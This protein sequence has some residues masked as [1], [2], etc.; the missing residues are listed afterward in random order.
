MHARVQRVQLDGGVLGLR[1]AEVGVEVQ[2]RA[3]GVVFLDHAGVHHSQ[4]SDSGRREVERDRRPERAQ[5]DH[6]RVC[7]G[8]HGAKNGVLT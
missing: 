7:V 8:D 2:R 5:A 3:A 4:P 6:D 1:D